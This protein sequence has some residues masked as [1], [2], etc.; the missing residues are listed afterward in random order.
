MVGDNGCPEGA[1]KFVSKEKYICVPGS[2]D[3][4]I[5][6]GKDGGVVGVWSLSLFNVNGNKCRESEW[7]TWLKHNLELFLRTHSDPIYSDPTMRDSAALNVAPS[8][9]EEKTVVRGFIRAALLSQNTAQFSSQSGASDA[10]RAS[11][12]MRQQAT[13]SRAC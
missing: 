8:R 7:A 1:D 4:E 13:V 10:E 2:E 3:W 6:V 9:L 5:Q 12:M 11:M